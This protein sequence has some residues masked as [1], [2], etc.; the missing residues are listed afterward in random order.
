MNL[1][2]TTALALI[3]LS[4]DLMAWNESTVLPYAYAFTQGSSSIFRTQLGEH[5][6]TF[7]E[8]ALVEYPQDSCIDVGTND[9]NADSAKC[10]DIITTAVLKVAYDGTYFRGWTGSISPAPTKH[11]STKH[12]SS[13][14]NE[15]KQRQSRRSRNLQRKGRG[16]VNGSIRTVEQTIRLSLAKVYGNVPP[17]NILFDSCSRTDAGVHATSLVAQFYCLSRKKQDFDIDA[18]SNNTWA[19]LRPSSPSDSNFLPLPF[20]ADLSKLVFVLNRM[21]PPDVRVVASSR[22]P[23]VPGHT[24]IRGD[25]E[26]NIDDKKSIQS[27]NTML[28]NSQPFHPTLHVKCKT[29]TYQ[30][31]VGPVQDPL[32]SRYVWHLD[33]SSARAVGM[34]GKKFCYNRAVEAAKVFVETVQPRD[35][36]AFRSAFRGNERGRVQSTI[37]TLWRCELIRESNEILPSWELNAK[38]G[39]RLQVKTSEL[40]TASSYNASNVGTYSIVITGDRFLYKMVRHIV[41]SIVSVACGHLE[42]SDIRQALNGGTCKDG[43]PDN[44]ET[45]SDT[46]DFTKRQIY[47]PARGLFLSDVDYPDEIV[48]DWH[49]G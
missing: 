43:K 27:T 48:F 35:Y 1:P 20:N 38:P 8:S 6:E 19:Q 32:R 42:V 18:T 26:S 28:L 44:L 33:G 13:A 24:S 17:E 45:Q 30:F 37:C 22:A 5:D 16:F 9:I 31:A 29:Y 36:A 49:T 15:T 39:S 10:N 4:I 25:P 7:I 2:P 40:Q 23:I 34:N 21:L 11:N 12:N 14:Y 47:A 3:F 46:N 41:G